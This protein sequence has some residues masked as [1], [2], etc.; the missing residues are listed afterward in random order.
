[1]IQT[2]EHCVRERTNHKQSLIP[3]KLPEYPWQKVGTDLFMLDGTTNLI[4]SNYYSRYPEVI[5]LNSTTS[6]SVISAPKSTFARYGISEELVGDN[7][8][9]TQPRNSKTSAR[10][11]TSTILP[12]V[13]TFHKVTD[14]WKC[15]EDSQETLKGFKRSLHDI[16]V[17]LFHLFPMMWPLTS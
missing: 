5:K 7:G 9:Q 14:M 13:L 11:T 3:S 17:I 6:L 2:C 12:V 1:M 16:A 4:T 8:P 10:N 15:N